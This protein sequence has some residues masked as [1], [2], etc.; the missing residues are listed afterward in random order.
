MRSPRAFER[1]ADYAGPAAFFFFAVAGSLYIVVA[2]FLYLGAIW[3]TSVPV[4]MMAVYAIA[5]FLVRRFRLRDDQTGDNFYY[6][7]FIFTLTSLAISLVQYGAGVEITEIVQNFGVAVATTIAGIIFRILFNLTRRDPVE[8]EHI[9]RIELSDAS[10]RVRRELDT[11]LMEMAHFRRTNQQML[12]EGFEEIRAEVLKSAVSASEAIDRTA[13][14]AE[15]KISGQSQLAVT[16]AIAEELQET[17]N[18]LNSLNA[19]LAAIGETTAEMARVLH[20]R[21]RPSLW[22]R[23]KDLVAP[24]RLLRRQPP[25][26]GPAALDVPDAEP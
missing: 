21:H 18:L 8:V 22:T 20:A 9:S 19:S 2:K 6:M 12:A 11:I 1:G 4:L 3:V 16:Q 5:I 23:L 24:P 15:Q 25:D 17:A 13:S 10:R 14:A 26:A 7:G